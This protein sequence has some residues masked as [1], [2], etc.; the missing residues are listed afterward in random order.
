MGKKK[1]CTF[2]SDFKEF[3][4]KGNFIDMA[5]GVV[6]GGAFGKIVTSLVNDIIMPLIGWLV[7]GVDLSSLKVELKG[8]LVGKM[9][10][11]VEPAYLNYGN[12]IQEI[13]DFIIIALCI[14]LCV[15]LITKI[16]KKAREKKAAEEAAAAAAAGPAPKP[17]DVALLEEIRDLLKEKK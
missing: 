9:A 14:F 8:S 13:V 15:R 16:G 1:K 2:W 7:G 10:A 5:I 4:V 17:E 11:D 3:A 6:V 12:F